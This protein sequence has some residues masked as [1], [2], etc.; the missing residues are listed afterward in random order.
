MSKMWYGPRGLVARGHHCVGAH[1]SD[2][3][4]LS[5][6]RWRNAL[7][8]SANFGEAIPT[9]SDLQCAWTLLLQSVY[10]RAI[11]CAPCFPL[12][13]QHIALHMMMAFGRHRKKTLLPEAKLVFSPH[14]SGRLGLRPER[15]APAACWASWADAI[16]MLDNEHQRWQPRWC[17]RW[18]P[19]RSLNPKALGPK[20][21]KPTCSCV[22]LCLTNYILSELGPQFVNNMSILIVFTTKCTCMCI[23][24]S[25]F[26]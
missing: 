8:K 16:Q 12:S 1:Q 25:P 7:R 26:V 14:A 6:G 17:R 22:E 9:V 3:N 19:G 2:Q 13:R 24:Q 5:P 20:W 21:P 4:N 10:P 11:P 18:E 23:C 15:C